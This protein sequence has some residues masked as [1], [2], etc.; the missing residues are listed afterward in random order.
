MEKSHSCDAAL[1]RHG[2]SGVDLHSAPAANNLENEQNWQTRI[3]TEMKHSIQFQ[4]DFTE[5]L[6]ITRPP[7]ASI[8]RSLL[9]LMFDSIST[10]TS[11]PLPPVASWNKHMQSSA[12]HGW[13]PLNM[14]WWY[15]HRG[16]SA[17][18]GFSRCI[19]LLCDWIPRGPHCSRPASF[20]LPSLLFPT[21]SDRGHGTTG[22]QQRPPTKHATMGTIRMDESLKI[23]LNFKKK[24]NQISPLHLLH[25]WEQ[26]LQPWSGLC[27]TVHSRARGFL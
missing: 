11:T 23:C 3:C 4:R 7:Y 22:M 18:P 2:V 1:F 6:T 26:S 27:N 20:L 14:T 12:P 9:R 13:T 24:I 10:T 5:L 21:P 8:W 15:D 25:G 17:V 16:V 19:P